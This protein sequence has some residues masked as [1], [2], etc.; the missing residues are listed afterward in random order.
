[1]H[2]D[3]LKSPYRAATISGSHDGIERAHKM[4]QDIIAEVTGYIHI[5]I[6]H[7]YCSVHVEVAGW[8]SIDA[9]W[10]SF[11]QLAQSNWSRSY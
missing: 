3:D 8:R 9:W 5:F 10:P 7:D 1:M 11:H 4:V 2:V 6:V